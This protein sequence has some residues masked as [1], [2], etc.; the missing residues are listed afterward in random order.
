MTRS[1]LARTLS[2]TSWMLLIGLP[3]C[4]AAP[5]AVPPCRR[6]DGPAGLPV[7]SRN[8]IWTGDVG[9]SP[10]AVYVPGT[11]RVLDPMGVRRRGFVQSSFR[12]H[13]ERGPRSAAVQ[14][15]GPAPEDHERPDRAYHLEEPAAA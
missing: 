4:R 11:S 1:T 9:A 15:E 3:S 5:T 2:P 10:Q 13:T 12:A 6:P 7:T 14:R 8:G